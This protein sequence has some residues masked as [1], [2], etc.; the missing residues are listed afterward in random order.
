[1]SIMSVQ[2]RRGETKR[3]AVT[4]RRFGNSPQANH[5]ASDAWQ[6]GK[7]RSEAAAHA[8]H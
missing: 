3:F 2:T 4:L 1:M 6:A 5:P 7:A 8:A